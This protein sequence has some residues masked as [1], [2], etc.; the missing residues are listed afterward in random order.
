MCLPGAIGAAA[1]PQ[2]G[3]QG[4][5]LEKVSCVIAAAA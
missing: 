3:N 2:A 1:V 5:V 4:P